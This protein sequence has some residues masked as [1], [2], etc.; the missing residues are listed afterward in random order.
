MAL[1]SAPRPS[2]YLI[3]MTPIEIV[4]HLIAAYYMNK[5]FLLKQTNTHFLHKLIGIIGFI[6]N[7]FGSYANLRSFLFWQQVP[8]HQLE[9]GIW[10]DLIV[11]ILVIIPTIIS[12]LYATYYASNSNTAI[13]TR[14]KYIIYAYFILQ[15]IFSLSI[16]SI[17][18]N[19]VFQ[20]IQLFYHLLLFGYLPLLNQAIT[21]KQK[22]IKLMKMK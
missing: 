20:M 12:I 11:I 7:F 18:D 10:T 14:F 21:V 3:W 1:V 9:H 8:I 19:D 15:S 4:I 2:K 17:T 16:L 13:S 6:A 22:Q 5:W